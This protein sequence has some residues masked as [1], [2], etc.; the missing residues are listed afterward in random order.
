MEYGGCYAHIMSSNE[1]SALTVVAFVKD[2]WRS[3]AFS[4]LRNVSDEVMQIIAMYYSVENVH[5]FDRRSGSQWR[6]SLYEI[7]SDMI[8]L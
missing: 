4:G 3:V 6:I 5:L 7:M 2:C 1:E 8:E